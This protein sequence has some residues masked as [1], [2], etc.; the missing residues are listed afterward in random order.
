MIK[1]ICFEYFFCIILITNIFV[2]LKASKIYIFK[3]AV[4]LDYVM[5]SI[6]LRKDIF[7]CTDL[8]YVLNTFEIPGRYERIPPKS[9]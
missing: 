6:M 8:L 2:Q 1:E 9:S 4:V 3:V 5:T 7:F